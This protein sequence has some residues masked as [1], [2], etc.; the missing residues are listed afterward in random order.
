MF[1]HSSQ[2]AIFNILHRF[3]HSQKSSNSS[4]HMAHIMQCRVACHTTLLQGLPNTP[5]NSQQVN[6][7]A[8]HYP[9]YSKSHKCKRSHLPSNSTVQ[10]LINFFT[11]PLHKI[12][13][14][15]ITSFRLARLS[16]V[17]IEFKPAVHTQKKLPYM[18]PYCPKHLSKVIQ[19]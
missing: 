3:L 2:K 12:H 17:S 15:T 7:L 18:E 9:M 19:N 1:K 4:L 6:Y 13:I 10:Q 11:V 8:W 14:L 5:P 16:I